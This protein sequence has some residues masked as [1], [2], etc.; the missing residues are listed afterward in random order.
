MPRQLPVLMPV[1]SLV[2][3]ACFRTSPAQSRTTLLAD[4]FATS[5]SAILHCCI[6]CYA[7]R[8]L[9]AFGPCLVQSFY[10]TGVFD[11]SPAAPQP[12][13]TSSER[14]PKGTAQARNTRTSSLRA[15]WILNR[16]SN[17]CWPAKIPPSSLIFPSRVKT[18]IEGRSEESCGDKEETTKR[19]QHS[20]KRA[21]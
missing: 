4:L 10:G 2:C 19:M 7:N 20:R 8:H 12:S 16:H 3:I 14:N 21:Q 17:R 15:C 9:H 5:P 13:F 6:Q 18:E 1:G 11:T